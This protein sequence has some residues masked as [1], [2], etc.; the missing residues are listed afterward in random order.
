MRLTRMPDE[1]M[2]QA[3]RTTCFFPEKLTSLNR[4]LRW[5]TISR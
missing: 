4:S 3:I 1:D 5:M 2:D